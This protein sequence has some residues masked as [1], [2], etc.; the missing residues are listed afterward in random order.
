MRILLCADNLA[1][2]ASAV[3]WLARMAPLEPSPLCIAAIARTPRVALRPSDVLQPIAERIARRGRDLVEMLAAPLQDRWRDLT[4]RVIEG[5]PHEHMLRA[6]AEWKADLVVVGREADSGE[7]TVLGSV[8]RV[9]AYHVDCSVLLARSA[10]ET[11]CQVLVGMDGSPSAREAVRLL[12]LFGLTPL[13]RVL[14][15]GIVDTAWR[16]GIPLGELPPETRSALEAIEVK[17]ARDA[18][19]ALERGTAALE[20]RASVESD[21]SVGHPAQVLLDAAR[22]WGASL[23]AIGHQGLEP[24]R[25]LSLGSVAGQILAAAPCSL[26]IGRK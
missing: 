25:R 26:L 3:S 15:L 20:G 11:A 18:R 22:Q 12:S 16:R 4:V 21:V 5:D 10:P 9:A 14:A 19:V 13:P 23:L 17:Q 8:A 1:D 6:A 24:V 2:T 7:S